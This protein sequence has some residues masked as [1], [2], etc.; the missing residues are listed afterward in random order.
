MLYVYIFSMSLSWHE[1]NKESES[2]SVDFCRTKGRTEVWRK[3]GKI[4]RI[5]DEETKVANEGMA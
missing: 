3:A 1:K 5:P 2:E 4:P